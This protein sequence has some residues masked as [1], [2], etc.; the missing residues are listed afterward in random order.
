MTLIETLAL[1]SLLVTVGYYAFQIAW[2][3]ATKDKDKKD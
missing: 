2:K 1:L 3:I